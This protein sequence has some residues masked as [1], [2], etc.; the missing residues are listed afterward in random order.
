MA[1]MRFVEGDGEPQT[2]YFKAWRV[3]RGYRQ[4]DA[5]KILKWRTGRISTLERGTAVYTRHTLQAMARVYSCTPAQLLGE[6]PP[7]SLDVRVKLADPTA[8]I[9]AADVTKLA[10]RTERLQAMAAVL[11][12][13]VVPQLDALSTGL[14]Q[15]DEI[16]KA[17][18]AI[19]AELACTF[20]EYLEPRRSTSPEP[21]IVEVAPA[22]SD[23]G[24]Q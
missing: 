20:N 24:Y 2:N 8:V 1:N 17:A 22:K 12:E 13:R 11:R 21:D 18:D 10:E 16:A 3:Y 7:G 4:S 19:A 5:E 14:S 15:V 23:P 9:A 6:P